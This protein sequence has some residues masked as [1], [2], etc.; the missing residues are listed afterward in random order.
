MTQDPQAPARP[1]AA[2]PYP[3]ARREDI[4]E[5]IH[6][7]LVADPYRWLEDADSPEARA[8]LAAQDALYREQAAALPGREALAARI[9][10]LLGAG[11]AGVP[12]WRGGRCFYTR[13]AGGQEHAV[14]YTRAPGVGERVLIDPMAIDPGGT[15]TLDAWQPDKEGRLLAYQLSEGGSEESV[16]RVMDVATGADVDGPIDRCRYTPVAWLPG[17]RAFYYARRLA[18]GQVPDGEEQFHRRVYRHEVGSPADSD[19]M[20]LGEGLDKTNY[21]DVSVSRD[22]RWL[23]ITAAAGTAPRNDVWLGD[24]SAAGPAGP[25]LAVVQQG[26][27]AQAFCHVGNDGRLYIFTDRDAPRGRLC[28]ADP[29]RPGYPDWRDLIGPDPEAVLTGYAIC[30]GAELARPVLLAC[31]T[32]HAIGEVTEHDLAAGERLGA[33]P[34]PGVGT[35]AGISE[36]PEG[37]HEAWIGYTDYSTP[38]QVLRY[39]ARERTTTIWERAPG[40]ADIPAIAARQVSYASADGTTVRMVVIS[41]DG[42]QADGQ[43]GRPAGPRPAILY[44]YGGFSISLTPAYSAAILAWVQAG[45]VYAIAGLRGGGEEGEDWHRAG[46]RA[47]K[48]NVFDDFRAAAD[49]L[50]AGGWTTSAQLAISGG[51]N[52]GLLVGAALTQWPWLYAAVMCSAPLLDMIRYEKFGLGETW[53]DEYGTVADPEEAGWLLAYSPYHHVR[54]GTAYP[55]TLF[56]VFEGDSRVDPLHARKMCAAV[57]H[58][59]SAPFAERPVLLRSERDVGHGARAISRSVSL[60]AETLAFAGWHT[61][62]LR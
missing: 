61:G 21:Y 30:D 9:G 28:V 20:I 35:V 8:W 37:G 25:V 7:H 2:R 26:A 50:I 29:A 10:Q 19:A 1:A 27:D 36:R 5:E 31:W 4:T 11:E 47:A 22:G 51:S 55:A 58:A 17:G 12:A 53:N 3:P 16:L 24:L 38:P 59:T 42:G 60:S 40:T 14:L 32:R 54:E 62:L 44:G 15:T 45:G 52:G 49:A 43:D 56:T 46:M 48:Q 13:R 6:G 34:L 57:Q 33:V 18:P 39:D 23:I 41:A